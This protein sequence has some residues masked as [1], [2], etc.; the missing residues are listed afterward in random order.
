[1]TSNCVPVI[2]MSKV[3]QGDRYVSLFV[4]SDCHL[5]VGDLLDCSQLTILHPACRKRRTE[6]NAVS[7]GELTLDFPIDTHAG[8]SL[9]VV[10]NLS[11]TLETQC[12][13]VLFMIVCH[14]SCVVARLYPVEFASSVVTDDVLARHIRQCKSSLRSCHVLP[15]YEDRYPAILK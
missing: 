11:S 5:S 15:I 1:M 9:R 6:L 4:Q 8:Q 12:D 3:I 7:A 2:E 14:H 10:S 13:G